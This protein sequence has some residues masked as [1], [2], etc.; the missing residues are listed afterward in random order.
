MFKSLNFFAKKAEN[1]ILGRKKRAFGSNYAKILTY[2]LDYMLFWEV[3]G[4]FCQTKAELS[5]LTLLLAL[6]YAYII[7]QRH[8]C[9]N[10]EKWG[11][12]PKPLLSKC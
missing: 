12:F 6:V 2:Y 11:H 5:Q 1:M 3:F 7:L 9:Q 4:I 8:I 10:Y